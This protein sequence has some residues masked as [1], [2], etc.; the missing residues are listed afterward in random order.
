MGEVLPSGPHGS[1][2]GSGSSLPAATLLPRC[3]FCPETPHDTAAFSLYWY[4]S[5][6]PKLYQKMGRPGFTTDGSKWPQ[7]GHKLRGAIKKK[8]P[9]KF[10]FRR[11]V[12]QVV[13]SEIK[14]PWGSQAQLGPAKQPGKVPR[15]T[16]PSRAGG[17]GAGP[18]NARSSSPRP[19]WG[20]DIRSRTH[21]GRREGRQQLPRR[22]GAWTNSGSASKPALA[23]SR[24]LVSPCRPA[25]SSPW[26]SPGAA[27][28]VK[29]RLNY[30]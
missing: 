2:T 29:A 9:R 27:K 20:R 13:T 15:V 19:W 12:I 14:A 22:R 3:P 16:V 24:C 10:P 21:S 17:H 23:S 6:Q 26:A 1:V 7:K 5:V 8:A 25:G 18:G 11:A 30:L 4:K 28:S